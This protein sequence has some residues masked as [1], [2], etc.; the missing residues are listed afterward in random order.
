[1]VREIIKYP[2]TLGLEFGGNVRFFNDELL[3]LIED[4][5][6]TINFHK[7]DALSAFEI[8]L[9]QAVIV[10][11]GE[12]GEYLELI[13]PRII[14]QEDTQENYETTPY[15]PVGA[16][17]QRA[18]KIKLMYENKDGKQQFLEAQGEFSAKLQ[19][20]LDFLFGSTFIVRLSDEERSRFESQ[21]SNGLK[22]ITNNG[23]PTVFKR[24]RILQ[25]FKIVFIGAIIGIVGSFFV[26]G[27]LFDELNTT[28]DIM[29]AT[30]FGLIV[31]YFFYAQYE[32]KQYKHCS[33]CQIGNIIGT[34][35]LLLLRTSLLA[36]AKFF[37][38]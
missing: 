16:N 31:V 37:L 8:G 35:A 10:I 32:G 13:N 19:Q 1:M 9:P 21:L 17:V 26:D 28:L 34:S 24:D 38:L 27:T 3:T 6:D 14:K 23:C 20:K 18:D 2:T 33:S 4:L 15:F 7:L 12:D 30:L 29:I 5:K 36:G 25:L 22:D 11:K